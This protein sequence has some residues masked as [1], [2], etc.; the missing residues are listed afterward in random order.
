MAYALQVLTTLGVNLKS[1]I[2][3]EFVNDIF[4]IHLMYCV[5]HLNGPQLA[6]GEHLARRVVQIQRAC[7]VNPKSPDFSGLSNYMR[8]MEIT[9]GVAYTPGFDKF[10]SEENKTSATFAKFQRQLK[11]ETDTSEKAANKEQNP[12]PPPKPPKG[13][14][15]K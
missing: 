10:I 6:V 4:A 12:R 8:H 3:I 15:K 14:D 7:R 13:G 5:D 11:E 9:T 1:G 2:A